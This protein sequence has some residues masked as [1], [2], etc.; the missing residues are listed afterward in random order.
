MRDPLIQGVIFIIFFV[1]QAYILK[2][3]MT[4]EFGFS[5]R[6]ESTK[7][8]TILENMTKKTIEAIKLFS[9]TA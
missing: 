3:K 8:T 5:Q 6:R 2:A 4:L 1:K 7:F 9:S